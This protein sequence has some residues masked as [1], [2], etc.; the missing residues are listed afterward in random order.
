MLT[1][2]TAR[3]WEALVT[4][5]MGQN[6]MGAIEKVKF[7]DSRNGG[8]PWVKPA[9]LEGSVKAAKAKV[10][11]G[12]LPKKE[13]ERRKKQGMISLQG[14]ACGQNN[15]TS[16]DIMTK[17]GQIMGLTL[18]KITSAADP[19]QYE[20]KEISNAA[21]EWVG[22]ITV[23]MREEGEVVKLYQKLHGYGVEINGT[24]YLVE[25]ENHLLDLSAIAGA[26]PGLQ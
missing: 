14:L 13:L 22:Q 19:K 9:M 4:Q 3:T 21:G 15:T 6:P 20:W 24:S 17:V 12:R 8:R 2:D 25:V 26:T 23:Q 1:N 10:T 11:A 18:I 5:Q 7:R 16:S